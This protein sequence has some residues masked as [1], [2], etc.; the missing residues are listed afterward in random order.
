MN[1][2]RHYYGE[3][4]FNGGD[5]GGLLFEDQNAVTELLDRNGAVGIVGFYDEPD[6]PI[7]FISGFA[8][9]AL[10]YDFDG[11]IEDSGGKFIN[12]LYEKDRDDFIADCQDRERTRQEFRLVRRGGSPVW[13]TACHK[14]SV[15]SEGRRIRIMSVRVAEDARRRESG[16][17]EALSKGYDRI[18]YV[19]VNRGRYRVVR[20]E[21]GDSDEQICAAAKELAELLRQYEREYISPEDYSFVELLG[22]LDLFEVESGGGYY[23]ATYRARVDG[24]CQ[25]VQ[26]QVFYGGDIDRD[27]GHILLT[28]RTVDEEKQRELDASRILSESLAKAEEAGRVKNKFLARMSHDLRTPI[29]GIIGL[30][31]IARRNPDDAGKRNECMDKIRVSCEYLL[32][33]V[34]DVLDMN[35][36]ENGHTKLEET[37]FDFYEVIKES[38]RAALKMTGA[39]GLVFSS[40]IEP[41]EHSRVLGSPKHIRQMFHHILDNAVKYNKPGGSVC[42]SG[43]EVSCSGRIA[44]YEF[45]FEDTGIGMSREFLRY[46]FEPFEQEHNE[47]RSEYMGTGLGMSIVKRLVDHMNGDILVESEAGERTKV[48]V[49]LPFRICREEELEEKTGDCDLTGVRVLLAEDNE[50]NMDIARYLLEDAGLEV[51]CAKNG[52]AALEMFEN[53]EE[54]EFDIILMDIMMPVM[55]GLEATRAIRNL[56]RADARNIPIFALSANVMEEDVKK[57]KMA[58]MNEHLSK[59]IDSSLMLK[60]IRKYV[61]KKPE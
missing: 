21:H 17:L 43:R 24:A 22:R 32:S 49:T 13:V 18:I 48:T 26:F 14:E 16:L 23:Q 44:V 2:P 28:F 33:L 10:G 54:N 25:W 60:E 45:I 1:L 29:N 19:D 12:V 8:L 15:S 30:L 40:R 41:F 36:L 61:Q 57:T 53:S 55:D 6:Y 27:T 7:C 38:E 37:V 59:P 42:V 52:R 31:D 51:S 58:G 50:L 46:I 11:L 3:L 5:D 39:K 9:T 34:N 20:M 4:Y 35:D 56:K 47:A